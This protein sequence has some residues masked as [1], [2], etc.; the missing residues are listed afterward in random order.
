MLGDYHRSSQLLAT[1]L[2]ATA[3]EAGAGVVAFLRRDLEG[4]KD[5]C[6]KQVRC[7]FLLFSVLLGLLLSSRVS[8]DH[9]T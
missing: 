3:P 6:A 4:S 2:V 9:V 8:L 7:S 1:D 5:E